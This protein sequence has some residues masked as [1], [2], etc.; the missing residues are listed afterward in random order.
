LSDLP[1]K[2]RVRLHDDPPADSPM[3][4]RLEGAGPIALFWYGRD[5][6]ETRK[7]VYS[8]I[9]KGRIPAGKLGGKIVASKRRLIAAYEQMTSGDA[10]QAE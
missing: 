10:A 7:R 6:H 8:L 5:T 9:S 1:H 3:H 2:Q 4:D